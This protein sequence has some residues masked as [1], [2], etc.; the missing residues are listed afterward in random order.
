MPTKRPSRENPI[1]R[2]YILQNVEEHP[3]DI[4]RITAEKF[5]LSR[6]AVNNYLRRLGDEKILAAEGKTNARTYKVREIVDVV[7]AIENITR[8]SSEDAVWRFRI[9]PHIKNVRKNVVD[10]CQYGF[11]EMFNNVVDHSVSPDAIVIYKQN[12]SRIKMSVIDEGVGIFEKIRKDF[13]LPDARSALLELSKGK[14]TSDKKNHAGE[15]IFYTS[16]MFDEFSINSGT[17]YYSRTKQED[18]DWLIEIE[19]ENDRQLGTAIFMTISLDADWTTRQVFDQYQDDNLRFRRTHV[20][21]KLGMYPG[22]QLVSRSQA[23]RV[24]ARF[25]EFSEI[26]LDFDGV[27]D[28]GQAFADEIFRVFP[29]SHPEIKILVTRAAD[30]VRKMIERAA[31]SEYDDAQQSLFC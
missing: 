21:I 9:L 22:E 26:M 25:D 28:I 15:G 23:K 20:P 29:H 3:K 31:S 2:E 10:I 14:I 8:H 6:T 19:E 18:D 17:L 11:T 1:V 5:N 7:F 24:L 4:A 27:E 16:R 30:R 13:G 12:F